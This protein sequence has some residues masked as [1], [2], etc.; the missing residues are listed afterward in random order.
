M[1]DLARHGQ[2]G[3][4]SGMEKS[5]ADRCRRELEKYGNKEK[6]LVL[7]NFF[8]TGKGEYGEGDKFLGITV[9]VIRDAVR[10]LA[11]FE[12]GTIDSLLHEDIHE[13]RLA[14]WLGLVLRFKKSDAGGKKECFEFACR[15]FHRANNW[16]LVDLSMPT[17]IGEYLLQGDRSCMKEWAQSDCLW[18]Q[19]TAMVSTITFLKQKDSSTTLELAE[20][21]VDHPHDLIRKAV[22]WMLRESAKRVS[23]REVAEFLVKYRDTMPRVALR[24]AIERFPG[25][26]KAYYMGRVAEPPDTLMVEGCC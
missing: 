7:A 19:R 15:R 14:G 3:Y 18:T 22:G 6:S 9:P 21:L 13:F 17:I 12:L 8:K 4:G 2:D 16:D 24:Y 25:Q 11:P 23:K 20:L 26:E 1:F 10:R 5:A